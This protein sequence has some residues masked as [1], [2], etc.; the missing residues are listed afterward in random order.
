VATLS[1][2]LASRLLGNESFEQLMRHGTVELRT[3]VPPTTPD[4]AA[5]GALVARITNGGAAWT[6]GLSGGGLEWQRV[7]RF[8]VP[9]AG[10]A[11][12]MTGLA[13]G[14]PTWF[15]VL[16]NPSE[17]S[18]GASDVLRVDGTI[19]A[20]DGPAV[21]ADLFLPTALVLAGSVRRVDN[22][23]FTII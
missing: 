23:S 12:M 13:A 16:A 3:G 14:T 9:A 7:G 20:L 21:E 4:M 17:I 10:Q 18:V 5:T 15:R 2:G 22:F 19:A 1:T 11:W 8:M 6:P